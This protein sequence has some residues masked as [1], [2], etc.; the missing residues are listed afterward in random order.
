[1]T[2]PVEVLNLA[3]TVSLLPALVVVGRRP[4]RRWRTGTAGKLVSLAAVLIV[5]FHV[6]A[7]LVPLG[8]IVVLA[9]HRHDP[10]D[11]SPVP[12]ADSWPGA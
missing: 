9:R 11:R 3:V 10:S 7:V 2:G 1:V 12:F 8:A 5:V 4:A 6:G